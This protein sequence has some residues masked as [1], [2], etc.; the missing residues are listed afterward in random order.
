[1]SVW[2]MCVG[3]GACEVHVCLYVFVC[4]VVRGWV[5]V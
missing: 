1:M 5:R 4:G 2:C 3:V